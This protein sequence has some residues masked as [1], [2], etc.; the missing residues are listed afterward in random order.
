ME[1][2]SEAIGRLA[3]LGCARTFHAADNGMLIDDQAIVCGLSTA[4]GQFGMYHSDH[5]PDRRLV[6][7]AGWLG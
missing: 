5:G 4:G 7:V 6:G 1:T 3:E 2:S